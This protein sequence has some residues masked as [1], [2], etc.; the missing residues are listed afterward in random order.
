MALKKILMPFN[1]TSYDDKALD[2][3]TQTFT[4]Q[5]DIRVTLFHT[6]IPLPQVNTGT[7][8]VMGK[9]TGGLTFLA[10]ELHDK[11]EGLKSCKNDLIQKGFSSDQIDYLFRERKRS[12]ADEIVE[13]AIKGGY[14]VLII[15]RQPGKVSRMFAR[16][17]HDKVLSSVTGMTVCLVS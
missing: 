4:G 6:Y 2:F 1:F 12:I 9:M 8:P 11:E 3:L 16:S 5:D 14:N 17:I 10:K 13:T 7:D 15:S